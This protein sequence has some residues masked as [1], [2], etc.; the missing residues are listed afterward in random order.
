MF[1]LRNPDKDRISLHD[2]PGGAEAFENAVRFLYGK[3]VP[4]T[5]TNVAALRCAAEYLEMNDSLGDGSLVAKTEH[6]LNL[7]VVS[8]WNDSIAVL[9]SCSDLKPWAEELEIVRR[10]SESVAW[11]AS[12]NP[13]GLR[14]SYSNSGGRDAARGWWFDDVCNL[15]ID[16]FS[17]VINAMISKG[18]DSTTVTAVVVQY[19]EKWLGLRKD[20]K[21]SE[22]SRDFAS[23]AQINNRAILQGI[24]SLLPM[25]SISCKFL[26]KLLHVACAVNAGAMC[27]T[28][29]ARRIGTQLEKVTADELL[30]AANCAVNDALYD[31]DVVQQIVEYYLREQPSGSPPLSPKS[32]AAQPSIAGATST[33]SVSSVTT[34]S[35]SN[36]SVSG[37]GTSRSSISG[38]SLSRT[39]ISG[40]SV[41][42]TTSSM[43]ES[44]GSDES[45]TS[46]GITSSS[47]ES[48]VK[49]DSRFEKSKF[50]S[51]EG[52]TRRP[53]LPATSSNLRVAR[54][55]ET[56]LEEVAKKS[57]IP[58]G[59]F[60][61]IADLFIEFPRE[62][63]DCVYRAVDTFLKVLPPHRTL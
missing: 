12:T 30:T 50:F 3:S 5:S 35:S 27:K 44:S 42:R 15:Y 22:F 49:L 34:T 37:T 39:S 63:D 41:S 29:L 24:V 14:S 10:C 28:D 11:K 57:S 26:L 13:H 21:P 59:K 8:S 55:L 20:S 7:V 54:I 56:F 36:R 53:Q 23:K 46:S 38:S 61:A 9:R 47:D 17:S 43:S 31:I 51:L 32:I 1:E 58:V 25:K 19:S 40:S 18:V 48:S 52:P 6:Y 62:S 2:I 45:T 16:T 60:V 4:L 33:T